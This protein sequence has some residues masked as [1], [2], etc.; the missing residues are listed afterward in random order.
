MLLGTYFPKQKETLV[1]QHNY[2][3]THHST[4]CHLCFNNNITEQQF[5]SELSMRH[6]KL[7]IK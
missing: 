2:E 3:K 7:S 4:T 6:V 1:L 5:F